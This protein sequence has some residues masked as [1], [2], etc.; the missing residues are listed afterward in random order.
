MKRYYSNVSRETFWALNVSRETL[1]R[2]VMPDYYTGNFYLSQSQM[3]V[4]ARYLYGLLALEGWS[5]NAIAA[6]C[7]NAQYEST[8][9]PG[10][11]QNLTVG[12]GGYGLVQWTPASKYLNFCEERSLE[13][14]SMESAVARMVWEV[15]N[16]QQWGTTSVYPISFQTFIHSEL[17]PYYL[18]MAFLYNYEKPDNLNQPAR[19]TAAE[20][21]YTVFSG[22]S[23]PPVKPGDGGLDRNT[24]KP[25]RG[26]LP[27]ILR[28]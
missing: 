27:A 5:L 10:I 4:N 18:A 21:W 15:A 17:S 6:V 3:E 28:R 25:R 11:W 7:G 23:P 13:P 16:N 8:I 19:G 9:N 12:T 2:I 26:I 24:Y 20:H 1:E 22:E 14:S